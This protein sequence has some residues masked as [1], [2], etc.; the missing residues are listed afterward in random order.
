MKVI[1]CL[2]HGD[3]MRAYYERLLT[4]D[5]WHVEWF[6][7]FELLTKAPA[8]KAAV[9]VLDLDCLEEIGLES[10]DVQ[11]EQLRALFA[12]SELIGLSSSD[13]PQLMLQCLRAGFS[14][15]LLKPATAEELAWSIQKCYRQTHLLKEVGG[16][17]ASMFYAV[18]RI[19]SSTVPTLVYFYTV[20]Y[21]RD[22][23][24]AKGAAWLQIR[25]R[26]ERM[27]QDVLFSTEKEISYQE[28]IAKIPKSKPRGAFGPKAFVN[29]RDGSRKVVIS[30]LESPEE[31]VIFWGISNKLTKKVLN[32]ASL[33]FKYSVMT[34]YHIKKLEDVRLQTFI[35]D[36][37]GLFN[38]RYLKFSLNLAVQRSKYLRQSFSVLFID[39]DHFKSVND[40]YGH[41]VGSEYLVAVGKSIRNTVRSMDSVFRYGGD[42]F[43]VI[44]TGTSLEEATEIAERIRENIGNRTFVI[45]GQK[46]KNTV[47]IGVATYP[48]HASEKEMILK[49]ADEALYTAKKNNRNQVYVASR[50]DAATP[51]SAASS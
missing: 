13:S 35:D 39:L 6:T 7:S 37:T 4:Q 32:L 18:S 14:D 27:V 46:L 8:D 15:L 26:H 9:V 20:S 1:Y 42:E 21:L 24:Q 11:M 49:L 33:L 34:L 51:S 23:L 12:S 45:Q 19:S 25:Q 36:L 31:I 2:Q 22:L 50:T 3:D 17:E 30:N 5:Q 48:L 41:L 28:V 38:S 47:S 16:S 40:Q 10:Q 44:L 29:K 43:V